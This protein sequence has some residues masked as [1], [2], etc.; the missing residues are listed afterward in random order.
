[1]KN[2]FYLLLFWLGLSLE[3]P[4]QA[5]WSA[6]F[7]F[8]GELPSNE[9]TELYQDEDGFVW[10]G[11]TNGLSRYDG[12]RLQ[13]FQTD[14]LHPNRLTHN[15][16]TCI[17]E[18]SAYLWIGTRKGLNLIDKRTYRITTPGEAPL[19]T[20]HI[21][22]LCSDGKSR[23][24]IALNDRLLESR[25]PY[26]E[27]TSINLP[28]PNGKPSYINSFFYEKG[29]ERLW[30]CTS[31][32]IF[33]YTDSTQDLRHLPPV[34]QTNSP[35]TLFQDRDGR[36]WLTTWGEGL[37]QLLTD[38]T[39]KHVKYIRQDIQSPRGKVADRKFFSTAQ[40]DT[41]GYIW[42][43]S[44]NNL[45][46]CRYDDRAGKLM[47]VAL[48]GHIDTGK[49]Y[50]KIL[51]DHDGNLWLSSY[52]RGTLLT[53]HTETIR[54][55]PLD[56]LRKTLDWMPNLLT[57]NRDTQ[58]R[59][60]FVQDRFGLCL[61]EPQHGKTV[62]AT[63]EIQNLTVDARVTASSPANG[64]LWVAAPHRNQVY[65]LTYGQG[66][67]KVNRRIRLSDAS[68]D[69]V[70]ANQM[71]ETSDGKLW[72]RSGG[73]MLCQPAD[74][75][76]LLSTPDS[77]H[78][79]A[80]AHRDAVSV[81]ASTSRRLYII[82]V[83]GKRMACIPHPLTF[84]NHEDEETRF[85]CPDD[86]GGFWVA[87]S[88]GRILYGQPKDSVFQDFSDRF[89]T[90][91]MTILNLLWRNHHLWLVSHNRFIHYDTQRHNLQQYT[92]SD[93]NM[94]TPIFRDQAAFL[95]ADGTLYAGGR[96]G[97]VSVTPPSSSGSKAPSRTVMLT[98][99][100]SGTR[101]MLFNPSGRYASGQPD[102]HTLTLQPEAANLSV[103]FSTLDYARSGKVRYA[104]RLEGL[105]TDWNYL[106]EGENTAYYQ[107][108]PKGYYRL[109][110]K[111]TD[112]NGQWQAPAT[113]LSLTQLPAWYET[114]WAYAAYVTVALFLIYVLL[115]LYLQRLR[116]RNRL[117]LQEALTQAKLDY[118]TNISHD[119]LT[120][121]SVISC[122]GDYWERKYP[123]E[124]RQTTVLRYNI[125]RL[126]RLL[127][128][129]L[130]FRKTENGNMVL[131]PEEGDIFAFARQLCTHHFWPLAEQKGVRLNL[132]IPEGE[133][134]GTLDFDKTDKILYNL[135][136]NA[137]KYTPSGKN[138]DFIVEIRQNG[139]EKDVI[140]TVQDEG[141][142][143]PAKE[144]QRIFD[145]FYTGSN[146][147]SGQSNGIGLAL[148]REL[149]TLHHGRLTLKSEP[150]KGSCFTVALPL[151]LPPTVSAKENL[152]IQ[153]IDAEAPTQDFTS[154]EGFSPMPQEPSPEAREPG[155]DRPSILLVDDNTQLL[156]M[157]EKILATKYRV[158]TAENGLEALKQL[159]ASAVDLIVSDVMMPGMDGFAL[160]RKLKSQLETSH[161]PVIMLTAKQSADDRVDCYEAGA[162]GYLAKPFELK[163]LAARIDNLLHT[164]RNRQQAFRMED[165]VRLAE[166]EYSSNDTQFLQDMA[167]CIH[168]HLAEEGFDLEQLSGHLNVSKS[169][170]HRKVKAMTGL[171][172]LEFIRNIR[173]KYAC[174]MLSRRDRNISEIAYATGF[175]SPKYFTKCFKEEFGLTPREYQE[176]E[177]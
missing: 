52:D 7:P 95:S 135:L 160:C 134:R 107:K 12:Y 81:W 99:F 35:F 62:F 29:K 105:D 87:T 170:L 176:K 51:K 60:W 146:G 50:T 97:F 171:T 149:T 76:S 158:L 41:F 163:V 20:A 42:A 157:M 140:F 104:Y 172:P 37:W 138:V 33:V 173:L 153:L 15:H 70:P 47:P 156:E 152:E 169:T 22:S 36:Y 116:N 118:F 137:V 168:T 3:V 162:D 10:I 68:G 151:D 53:F 28:S 121:L 126:K 71:E 124:K 155:N 27:Y 67:F 130:D 150:G 55:Y 113:L 85:L 174:E 128:Q 111:A 75:T 8:A 58:G 48:P 141:V 78:F 31:N 49:M 6:D 38:E 64:G 73:R 1:M 114:M 39:L 129:V 61:H 175:S 166:L 21:R 89:D 147:R 16:I 120:P 127:Q 24:W 142:G 93:G 5:I 106:Q 92:S 32:G 159:K 80:F 91:G 57:L 148:A 125:Y 72:L 82:K 11:T 100:K 17:A 23:I 88:M 40:D 103:S 45:Y 164:Y 65:L 98:D 2:T 133:C 115:R 79:T 9:M 110:V 165:H 74:G 144:Q 77:L 46:A 83:E 145:R 94:S 59:F 139:T 19:Q 131:R 43:L 96:G 26:H 69:Y 132:R 161:I 30:I 56:D 167:D 119:L 109:V 14:Y 13:T 4:A 112:R 154:P 108:L 25:F 63:P 117:Q 136:S 101:S 18:D 86:S 54:N 44:Y 34:G 123:T 90:Q 84:Q 66:T 177:K 122:V 143:I 102:R